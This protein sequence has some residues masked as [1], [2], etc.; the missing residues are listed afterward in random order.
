MKLRLNKNKTF[1]QPQNTYLEALSL[2][3]DATIWLISI[4]RNL[5]PG[6]STTILK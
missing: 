5:M 1:C 2:F 3:M 6:F 4:L